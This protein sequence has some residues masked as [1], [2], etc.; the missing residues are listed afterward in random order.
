MPVTSSANIL[1][2]IWE[3]I[4]HKTYPEAKYIINQL[5]PW[6]QQQ[7]KEL[8]NVDYQLNKITTL[9]GDIVTD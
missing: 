4:Q 2:V 1:H 6:L 9:I 7:I 8:K 3:I 5:L